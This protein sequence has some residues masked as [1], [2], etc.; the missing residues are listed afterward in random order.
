MLLNSG[1]KLA[2]IIN[3]SDETECLIQ[4]SDA[5]ADDTFPK[6]SDDVGSVDNEVIGCECCCSCTIL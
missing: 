3:F 6:I 1:L 5:G 4:N 2:M